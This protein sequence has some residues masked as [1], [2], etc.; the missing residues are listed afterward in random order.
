MAHGMTQ[1]VLIA[2]RGGF[3]MNE[4]AKAVYAA[5]AG[6]PLDSVKDSSVNRACPILIALFRRLGNPKFASHCKRPQMQIIE[7]P[8]DM[9]W[10]VIR[11]ATDPSEFVQEKGQRWYGKDEPDAPVKPE[12]RGIV[13]NRDYG[14]FKLSDAAV[15]M[16]KTLSGGEVLDKDGK[17]VKANALYRSLAR[18]D[19]LLVR[20]VETL[21]TEKAGAARSELV[22]AQIPADVYAAGWSIEDYDGI[23]WVA[24]S[25]RTWA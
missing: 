4:E 23:E 21:G 20:V 3:F 13:V 9:E 1:E 6:L 7:I 19:P 22:V 16:Y 24:E 14:G 10:E 5:E 8:A 25:H 12:T 18:D 17:P 11:D 15:E 2:T